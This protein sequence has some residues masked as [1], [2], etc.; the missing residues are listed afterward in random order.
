MWQRWFAS[1]AEAMTVDIAGVMS[2]GMLHGWWWS[3]LD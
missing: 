2:V 3:K 1:C